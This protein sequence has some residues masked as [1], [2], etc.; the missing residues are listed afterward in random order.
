MVF[1]FYVM[2]QCKPSE[3]YLIYF[4]IYLQITNL[5][6]IIPVALKK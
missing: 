5:I 1:N 4:N 6:I 3:V 2:K